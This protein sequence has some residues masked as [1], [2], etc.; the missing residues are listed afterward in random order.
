MI[1]SFP[2]P[3]KHSIILT[4]LESWL[5]GVAENIC[6]VS[7]L[8]RIPFPLIN[9]FFPFFPAL[10]RLISALMGLISALA[11]NTAFG[12]YEH[13][14]P[15]FPGAYKAHKCASEAHRRASE[16]HKRA[17]RKQHCVWRLWTRL[18]SLFFPALTSLRSALMIIL[19]NTVA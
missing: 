7:N 13:V 4:S 17:W 6:V 9:T 15:V 8:P 14:F 10:I 12:A 16:T 11:N 18:F 3:L 5:T 1:L 19:N 2:F